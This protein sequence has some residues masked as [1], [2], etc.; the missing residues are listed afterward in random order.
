MSMTI[1]IDD[2][3]KNEFTEVCNEIGMSASTA[4]NI[5]AKRVVREKRIPFTLTSQTEEEREFDRLGRQYERQLASL[6]WN[7]YEEAEAGNL[8][9]LDDVVSARRARGCA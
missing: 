8:Y 1:S 5:F 2:Q 4:F 9:T 7:A 3:L 6:A